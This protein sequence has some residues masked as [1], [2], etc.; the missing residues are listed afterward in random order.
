MN[1]CFPVPASG[2]NLNPERFN[3]LGMYARGSSIL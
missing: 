3:C 2:V 1:D